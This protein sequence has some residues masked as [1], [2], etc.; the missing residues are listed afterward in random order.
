MSRHVLALVQDEQTQLRPCDDSRYKM[1]NSVALVLKRTK[2]TAAVV[3]AAC[4]KYLLLI[5]TNAYLVALRA[6]GMLAGGAGTRTLSILA[7]AGQRHSTEVYETDA[8]YVDESRAVVA[9]RQ[10]LERVSRRLL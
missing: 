4:A 8:Q 2:L 6:R 10:E 9:A 1:G 5:S 3:G 7:A